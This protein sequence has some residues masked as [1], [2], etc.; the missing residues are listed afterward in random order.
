MMHFALNNMT[1][2]GFDPVSF[3]R[4][5]SELDC[6]GVEFRNDLKMPLF[7]D[8]E[9]ELVRDLAQELSI[10]IIALAE[11]KAFNDVSPSMRSRASE[12]ILLAERCGAKSIS[13]IPRVGGAKV[14]RSEQ[15]QKLHDAIL[16]L[17]PLLE[18]KDIV[19]LIEPIGFSNSTLRF[20]EDVVEI[21]EMLDAA[22]CFKIVHDT[23]HH[24]LADAGPFFAE[25]TGL[26]H[27]SGVCNAN[28]TKSEMRDHHR[29]LV[30]VND[31][32]GNIEQIRELTS[33]GYTGAISFEAFSPDFHSLSDPKAELL[34]S[35]NFINSQL[36]KMAA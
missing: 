10:E 23:F 31:M 18:N 25:H 24:H 6:T 1:V 7:V 21:I 3:L 28:L 29:E 14:E 12:L 2:P 35:F 26:V 36:T 15:K 27:I 30:D 13:L 20:K 33:K 5:A 11:V 8:V 19:G 34:R 32:L 16:A 17:K 4:L 22:D 9:P